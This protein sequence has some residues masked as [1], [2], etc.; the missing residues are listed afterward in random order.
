MKYQK[1]GFIGIFK[2]CYLRNDT[3]DDT[4]LTVIWQFELAGPKKHILVTNIPS[5][6]STWLFIELAKQPFNKGSHGRL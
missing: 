2:V 6:N 3:R 1:T 4:N 5:I